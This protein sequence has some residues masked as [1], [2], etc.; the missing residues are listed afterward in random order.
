M[1]IEALSRGADHAWLVDN[2]EQASQIIPA[3][4]TACRLAE[5]ATLIRS[6][7]LQA[8]R[9]LKPHGPFDVIFLDPPYGKGMVAT[10]LNGISEESL[11]GHNGIICAEAAKTDEVPQQIGL[12]F[13]VLS[14]KYGITTIHF[15]IHSESEV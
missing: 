10:L 11:L 15:Y 9:G 5:R 7:A 3:N 4:L 8:L 1:A 6:D 2:G 13:R 12:F 14:R